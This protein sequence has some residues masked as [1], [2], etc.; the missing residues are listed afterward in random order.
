MVSIHYIFFQLPGKIIKSTKHEGE[1][2]CVGSCYGNHTLNKS[3]FS[4]PLPQSFN[5][6][7]STSASFKEFNKKPKQVRKQAQ[8]RLHSQ[9]WCGETT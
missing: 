4:S 8:S 5:H 1:L 7:Y 3:A 9:H 2:G 6:I